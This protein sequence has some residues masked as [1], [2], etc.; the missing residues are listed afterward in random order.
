M[1]SRCYGVA[2]LFICLLP[3]LQ[4][5][6]SQAT[7]PSVL[8]LAIL[9]NLFQYWDEVSRVFG[10]Y[11]EFSQSFYALLVDEEER[12]GD[13]LTLQNGADADDFIAFIERLRGLQVPTE[14]NEAFAGYG[15]GNQG[16]TVFTTVTFAMM[17]LMV[18][19]EIHEAL[20]NLESVQRL[21]AEN[22][23]HAKS[24][25]HPYDMRLIEANFDDLMVLFE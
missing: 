9:E 3:G 23:A 25:F 6:Y 19:E 5:L 1:G 22:F 8:S 12:V 10:E 2:V 16:Y 15:L 7:P 13:A 20:M 24:A 21:Y 14:V 11:Q 18:E 4:P 17:L